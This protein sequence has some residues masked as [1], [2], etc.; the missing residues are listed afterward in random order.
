MSVS[1]PYAVFRAVDLDWSSIVADVQQCPPAS[2]RALGKSPAKKIRT[3]VSQGKPAR[4]HQLCHALQGDLF[5]TI[6]PDLSHE[7]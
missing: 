1:S 6:N 2:T 4:R 7:K 3:T 5:A